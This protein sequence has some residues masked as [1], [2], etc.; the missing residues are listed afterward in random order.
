MEKCTHLLHVT[1]SHASSDQIYKELSEL[2]DEMARV[3][4]VANTDWVLLEDMLF[5]ESDKI[6][7]LCSHSEKLALIFGMISTSE[8]SELIIT[9]NLRVCGDCHTAT[10][11]IARL[12]KRRIVIRDAIRWH[13]FDE[14]TG[15]C[16]CNDYY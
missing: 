12:R 6:D 4:Y 8:G 10:K 3:G 1:K 16:S 7:S 2:F 9:K 14:I 11:F 15:H 13:H 5:E